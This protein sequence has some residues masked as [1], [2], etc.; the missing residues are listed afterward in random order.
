M[1]VDENNINTLIAAELVFGY[2]S[3]ARFNDRPT[4]KLIFHPRVINKFQE[5]FLKGF[6][7]K[8]NTLVECI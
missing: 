1:Y 4:F 5:L 8:V 7:N 3:I 2:G 6:W